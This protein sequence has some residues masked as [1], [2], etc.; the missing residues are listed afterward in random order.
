MSIHSK[1]VIFTLFSLI[2]MPQFV[3]SEINRDLEIELFYD[4]INQT[5]THIGAQQL[6]HLLTNP[7]N[8]RQVLEGRQQIIGQLVENSDLCSQLSTLLTNFSKNE[9]GLENISR[10]STDIESTALENLYFSHDS[11]KKYNHDP[12]YLELGQVAYFGN[13]CSSLV[14]H[15]L[16]Y[17]IFTWG[18]EEKHSD[19]CTS[20]PPEDH[21]HKH[22]HKKPHTHAHDAHKKDKHHHDHSGC[23]DHNCTKQHQKPHTHTDNGTDKHAEKHLD[24]AHDTHKKEKHHHDHSVCS[25]HTCTKA[26]HTHDH[27]HHSEKK[28]IQNALP[29]QSSNPFKILAQSPTFRSAFKWWHGIAQIQELYG[30]QAVVRNHLKSI[31]EI[32]TQL[33]HVARIIDTLRSMQA[34]LEEHPQISEHI[35]HYQDLKNTCLSTDISDKLATCLDLLKTKTFT[36]KPSALSRIGVILAT[37]KLLQEISHELEPALSAIGEIDAYLNCAELVMSHQNQPL[38]YSFAQYI[39][40]PT[41]PQLSADNLWHPLSTTENTQLNSIDL[42]LNNQLRNIIVTGPNACGKSTNLKA[43]TLCA[44]LA[45]TLT[46]VPAQKYSHTIYK[47]IYSS[48][49]VT[50]NISENMSLFVAELSNAEELLT[51]I[52][53]LQKDEYMLVALDELFKSTHH[54]KGKN[55]AYRLLQHLYQSP[56]VITLVAT[57]F[58]SLTALADTPENNCANY[59]LDNFKLIPGVCSCDNAFDIVKKHTRSRLLE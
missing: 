5:K 58:E 23:T 53:N 50:D 20:C 26:H 44:Y 8:N 13:L 30:I 25:D 11:L 1:R 48:M 22:H 29:Q 21:D 47:E 57:H 43:I 56:Q 15:S 59:T 27:D 40:H 7:I 51:R 31:T 34:V 14:Q 17:A 33:M 35:T 32:Q 52:E 45:Q 10:P 12:L 28:E 3:L 4:R 55:V 49:V 37:Y 36:G 54:E 6:H 46:I 19:I 9:N 18:L 2:F 16:S 39:T 24:H 38:R 41:A 42:G